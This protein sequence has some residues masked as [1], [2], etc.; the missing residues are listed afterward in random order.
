M[1]CRTSHASRRAPGSRRRFAVEAAY[2]PAV[3]SVEELPLLELQGDSG[4]AFAV[5]DP[6]TGETIREVPRMGAA[7]T[8]RALRAAEDAL[9]GWRGLLAKERARIMRRWSDLM[10]EHAEPLARL[11]TTEQGKP[12]AE[13]RAEIDYA[14]SF[15]EWFGEEA[16][17]V[18]G[19]TIP[20]TAADRRIVVLKEPVGVTAGITPWNF[21]S[22]MI[23]RKCAPALA[24]GCTMVMKPA[25]QTPLSA[26]A[27]CELAE[28]A[29][30]PKGVLS[31]ITTDADG[32]PEVGGELTSNPLVRKLG[33]TGSTEVG[34]LL[35]RQCAGTVKK[36]SLELGGNAPFIVFDDADLDEAVAGAL[37]CK[38]RN[39]GQTCISANRIL[40]QD[41]VFDEFASR[42]TEAAARLRVAPGDEEGAQ[43]GPLIDEQA[44]AKVERHV[45]DAQ[46]KGAELVLGGG[47]HELGRTFFEPTLLTGV[48]DDT[49]MSC[50][51]TFGPVAGLTR[52]AAEED[53][54]RAAIDTPYGLAAYFYSRDVGRIWRVSEALEFGIVGVNTGFISTEVAPFGGMKESGIGREGSKYGIEEWLEIK[55]L[56]LGGIG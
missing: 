30:L 17:R 47:R 43:V 48:G 54:I 46:E 23:T 16:K 22:A 2:D 32:A 21:P 20:A 50:E 53:A 56:A 14:A 9:P 10:L 15:L 13:S 6:A 40:V 27:L 33:F 37:V 28:E 52:F 41:G 29:G 51:E 49:A 39:S 7:E 19:D 1:R 4:E 44:L 42:L 35:M 31:M 36:V 25:E 3:T 8:E 26:L 12:L 11:M 55:Y 18:Y 34:K 38:F 5:D 45:A 24:A